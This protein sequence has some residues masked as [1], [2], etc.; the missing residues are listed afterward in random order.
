MSII[1]HALSPAHGA[2]SPG[3]VAI[4]KDDI[5]ASG[6]P[7]S[8]DE[9]AGLLQEAG[10]ATEFLTSEGLADSRQ[11]ARDRFDVLLLP[12]GASFPVAAADNF[13]SFLRAGGKFLSTGGYAFDNLLERT[14]DGWR[15]YQPPAPSAL[16]G[17]VWFCDIPAAELRG[18]GSLHFTGWLKSEAVAGPGFAHFSIYQVA[19]DGSLPT[20]KDL[21]QV[22]GSQDWQPH[23]FTFDVHPKAATVSLRAGLYRCHGKAWFDDVQLRDAQGALLLDTSF[24]Q[25]AD[26][27]RR[28]SRHWWRSH[29]ALCAIQSGSAHR[30]TNALQ[31]ALDFDIPRPEQLNTRHGRPE[32]GLEVDRTQLGVFQ[33]DYLVERAGSVAAAPMQAIVDPEFNLDG[34]VTG[35]AACGVVGWDAAR[36]IPLVNAHD[37]FGRLRGAAGGML[38]H[39]A[40]PWAGSSWAFFG[41][42]NRDLFAQTTPGSADLLTRVVRSLVQDTYLTALTTEHSCYRQ[43]EAVQ[44]QAGVFNGGRQTRTLRLDLA[45]HPGEPRPTTGGTGLAGG[46]EVARLNSTVTVPAGA[47]NRVTLSWAPARFGT[48]FYYLV[49]RLWNGTNLVD[50]IESGFVVRD[51]QT[52]ASG[53]KLNYRENYLHFGDRP[54]FLFGTDDWGYVFNTARETPLQWLRD[55]RQRRDLG[56]LLYENL[57]FGLP[58]SPA[59]QEALFRKLDG[60]IQLAQKFNQ[61]YFAGLLIGYNAAAGD[62]DLA[63]Q[64]RYCGEF[65]QRYSPVPGLIYYLNGDYRCTLNDAVTPQWNQF[66]RERYGSDAALREAWG[67]FAPSQPL[68]QIPAQDYNDWEQ[69]WDDLSAYDRN[70]FRAWLLRRW[71]ATL[72]EAIRAHDPSHPT[73]GEFYQLPHGGVDLAAGIDGLDLAN[74]GYFEKPSRDLAAFPAICRANDQRARGK[75]NGPGEYGV[76]THPAWGDGRD[77]GYHTART[78]EEAIELFLAI[79]HYSLGLGASRIHNW[80]W[81]DDAHRVFPWGMVYPCDGVP[82]DTAWVHRNL[83]LLFRHFAPV[84]EAPEVYVLTPDTHRLGGAKWRVTDGLL[85]SLDLALAMHVHNL[86]VLNEQGLAIPPRAKAIFYPLPFCPPDD[87][88]ATLLRWVRNG[89]VLYL[90]GDISYDERRRRNRTGRLEE[91]CGVRFVSE[92]FAPLAVQTTNSADQPCIVVEPRGASVLAQAPDGAPLLLEN[93]VGQG[94]VLF[95]SDPI[96]LHSTPA[97]RGHDLSVYRRVLETANLK[98]LRLEPDDPRLHFFRVSL[99]NQGAVYILFNTDD[100]QPARTVTLPDLVEPVTLT[101]AR[102]RPAL[103]W[104]DGAGSVRAVESQGACSIGQKRL[105]TDETAGAVLTLDGLDVRRSRALLWMPLQ[106]GRIQWSTAPGWR[107]PFVETGDL[108]NGRWMTLVQEPVRPSDTA[109]ALSVSDDQ[110]FS[111]LLVCEKAD[112]ARWRTAVERALYDPASLP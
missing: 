5:P 55:M 28:E 7:S 67:P 12:Y 85:A 6:A 68:G 73:S 103:L 69:T 74:F 75:S 16:E 58:R 38:R 47:S 43:G 42:T 66:L 56:V 107:D 112:R 29:A 71:N 88:C 27:D 102:R 51:D 31:A 39:Y 59:Q 20:W 95:A 11:L 80:C 89:G 64:S 15:P 3:A 50:C 90:S 26:P 2:V 93:R 62:A 109:L 106:P 98:P 33:P 34:P 18:R 84:D 44:F 37:R 99:R 78:R 14:S 45:I 24:E 63:A 100:T 35:W 36:W 46:G 61:V 4:F 30:G 101:V 77:Y 70:S 65:A 19:A 22:R 40:G 21:C 23:E 10:F 48:D 97:R 1:G 104:L 81:K 53:P 52:M 94:R 49:G 110:A 25:A 111:L 96:E 86:G 8:P 60:V 72:I 54:L 82:K 92:R 87:A 105:L 57:Q 41:V 83:S 17:V 76:K 79:P 108:E 32:D 9:L 91:L 13:R